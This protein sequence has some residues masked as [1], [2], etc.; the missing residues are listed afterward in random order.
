MI[1]CIALAGFLSFAFSM[2]RAVKLYRIEEEVHKTYVPVIWAINDY[3]EKHQRYPENLEAL[4]PGFIEELPVPH[5][6]EKI[7]YHASPDGQSWE[8]RIFST[9]VH[10]TR[11]Y[12]VGTGRKL[13]EDEKARLIKAFHFWKV[14]QNKHENQT[15]DSFCRNP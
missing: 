8:L 7:C 5:A 14:I 1:V 13:S 10:P 15:D 11:T 9:R 3:Q 2:Y 6:Y 12:I 4:V